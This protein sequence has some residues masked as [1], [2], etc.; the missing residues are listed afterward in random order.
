M[1]RQYGS[2]REKK[3]LQ[4]RQHCEQIFV[5][6]TG[7]DTMITGERNTVLNIQQFHRDTF[8]LELY[9]YLL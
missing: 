2:G 7:M 3:R 6:G 9:H 1:I 5:V 8:F 4:A